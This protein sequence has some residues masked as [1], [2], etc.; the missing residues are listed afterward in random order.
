MAVIITPIENNQQ[1]KALR[2]QCIGASE[3][4]A[5]RGLHPYLTH[6]G[7]WGRKSG[8]LP[9]D[10]EGNGAMERG[11]D[12]EELAIKKISQRYPQWNVRAPREHYA[13]HTFGL[14]ATP[15][16]FAHDPERGDGTIQIKSVQ[17]HIFRR[18][19]RGDSDAVMPPLHIVIQV[20][21]EAWLTSASWAMI[22]ALV[23][24]YEIELHMIEVPHPHPGI[25]ETLQTDALE[26]W[27]LV[28][29]GREPDPD[30]RRDGEL[31]RAMLKQD[32]GSEIDLSGE[33]DLP[34]LLDRR[35]EALRQEKAFEAEAKA[36]NAELLHKL[37]HARIG[38]FEGGY[39]SAKTINKPAHEVKPSSYRMLRVVRNKQKN[40][41]LDYGAN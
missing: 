10:D 13:D 21:Q 22:A 12:L 29:S 26:F 14:G 36:I 32:D 8:R 4:A 2:K 9:Q 5:L 35:D 18:D 39:I 40:G 19:W 1:W 6:Y 7:L 38:R 31:I 16:C 41:G 15:D 11:R 27:Q 23:I 24:D 17:P 25:I 20:L 34:E 33:N 37:G 28:L 3:A 30:F